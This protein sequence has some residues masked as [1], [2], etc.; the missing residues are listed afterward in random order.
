MR[1]GR[2]A[3][4]RHFVSWGCH[5][6]GPLTVGSGCQGDRSLM[7]RPPGVGRRA[8]GRRRGVGVVL[9]DGPGRARV[10]RV[11]GPLFAELAGTLE[12]VL[13][14]V[15]REE[16][17]V[18]LTEDKALRWSVPLRP[19]LCRRAGFCR[20][21]VVERLATRLS[22]TGVSGDRGPRRVPCAGDGR[23]LRLL[24][25][26]EAHPVSRRGTGIQLADTA[27]AWPGPARRDSALL[28]IAQLD[29]FHRSRLRFHD[30]SGSARA[31]LG[32]ARPE[33]SG[34]PQ[35][36]GGVAMKCSCAGTST[37]AART[38][39]RASSRAQ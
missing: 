15:A 10:P 29:Q 38:G 36:V 17:A 3:Y 21:G 9:D 28:L 1:Q 31:D 22:V 35:I 5:V 26:A 16:C 30:D 25:R 13:H 33:E 24:G 32:S 37:P 20:I 18:V 4:V 39:R 19:L 12:Q 8:V 2:L 27:L 14:R 7:S 23:G 6:R 34:G 11:P